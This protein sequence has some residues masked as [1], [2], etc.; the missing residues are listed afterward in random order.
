MGGRFSGSTSAGSYAFF[1][2]GTSNSS[3]TNLSSCPNSLDCTLT[4]P[5]QPSTTDTSNSKITHPTNEF[6]VV[7]LIGADSS[8]EFIVVGT[9]F[10]GTAPSSG[11]YNYNLAADIFIGS[12]IPFARQTDTGFTNGS[13]TTEF[14]IYFGSTGTPPALG[15]KVKVDQTNGRSTASVLIGNFNTSGK[16]I[17]GVAYAAVDPSGTGTPS[18]FKGPLA[19]ADTNSGADFFG[20]T[21]PNNFVLNSVADADAGAG[22]GMNLAGGG[23]TPY[24]PVS[25]GTIDSTG[26]PGTRSFTG[27]TGFVGGAGKESGTD[28]YFRTHNPGGGGNSI[29]TISPTADT[30]AA[31]MVVEDASTDTYRYQTSTGTSAYIDNENFASQIEGGEKNGTPTT[32]TGYV[33]A[34]EE[35]TVNGKT[36]DLCSSCQFLTWGVWGGEVNPGT[37]PDLA[38]HMAGWVAGNKATTAVLA[39]AATKSATYTG[40]V[41]GTV[42]D[43]N[44]TAVKTGT[45][46][47][48]VTF[49]STT[50][51]VTSFSLTF[52]GDTFNAG[53]ATGTANASN[54]AITD[55][56]SVGGKTM[57][58]QGYLFG[59]PGVANDPPPEMAGDFAI[60]GTGYNAGGVFA[61]RK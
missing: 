47:S 61:G 31:D 37:T 28:T 13:V 21:G 11:L 54:F 6:V 8:K 5:N 42:L 22:A 36:F 20:S 29:I 18:L 34:T 15:T 19:T 12:D 50:Y 43:T 4:Y 57:F 14:E 39:A 59:T 33:V 2:P 10:T 17:T 58:A 46:S 16:Y 55:T 9:E 40:N 49:G 7:D 38:V 53:T 51:D 23:G 30:V 3:P 44:G 45:F 24:Y 35:F 27:L 60:S 48:G 26:S 56:S 52:N 32:T 1:Y 41:I 25:V